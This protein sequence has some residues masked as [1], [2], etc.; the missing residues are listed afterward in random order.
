MFEDD[1]IT[2][3]FYNLGTKSYL[4]SLA[5]A[6]GEG[7]LCILAEAS[8]CVALFYVHRDDAK[9]PKHSQGDLLPVLVFRLSLGIGFY[10]KD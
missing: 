10:L 8:L 2:F 6:L 5:I 3:K 7:P 4:L 9:E 1:S